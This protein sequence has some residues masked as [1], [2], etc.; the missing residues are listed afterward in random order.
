MTSNQP[1]I[2]TQFAPPDRQVPP[3][4]IRYVPTG[5]L[6]NDPSSINAAQLAELGAQLGAQGAEKGATIALFQELQSATIQVFL[7]QMPNLMAKMREW[8]LKR[9]QRLLEIVRTLPEAP[10]NQGLLARVM[11]PVQ[12]QLN[13]YVDRNQVLQAIAALMQETPVTR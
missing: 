5:P 10:I 2:P 3:P 9:F 4:E 8:E 12:P 6:G 7:T 1:A 11:G 13:S